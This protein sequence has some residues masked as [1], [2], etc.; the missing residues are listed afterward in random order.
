MHLGRKLSAQSER[1]RKSANGHGQTTSLKARSCAGTHSSS[2][3]GTNELYLCLFM[4]Y[5]KHTGN[6]CC[7]VKGTTSLY[8]AFFCQA[9]QT[10]HDVWPSSWL[11]HYICIFR[12]LLPPDRNFATCKIYLASKSCILL[13]WQRYCTALQQRA[14]AKL[15]AVV[16]GMEL[17][18]IRRGRHLGGHHIGHRPTFLFQHTLSKNISNYDIKILMVMTL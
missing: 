4:W 15:C 14:S 11:V 5:S 13:Y 6:K 9:N 10:L 16:Q 3:L 12:G 18:N 17:R 2:S 7:C 8:F 1:H